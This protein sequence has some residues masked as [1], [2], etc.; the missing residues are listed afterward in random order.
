MVSPSE[1]NDAAGEVGGKDSGT[2]ENARKSR[3]KN[4]SLTSV[5][6]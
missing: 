5:S 4:E 2:N 1:T 3:R 6:Q